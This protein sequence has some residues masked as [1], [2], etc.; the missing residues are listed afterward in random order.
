M[1]LLAIKLIVTPLVVLAATLAA[2]RWG[3]AVGGWLVGLPLTSGPVS[4]FLALEQG[5]AFAAHAAD[6]SLAGVIA[7]AAF[8]FGYA[9]LARRGAAAALVSGTLAYGAFAA[10]LLD[11]G[12]STFALFL[13]TVVALT[14]LLWLM[15][16]HPAQP[17]NAVGWGEALLRMA[18]TT[19][20]VVGLTSAATALGPGVAG[21]AA[22]FPLIGASIAVFAQLG[23]G[24]AAGVAVMRGMASALYAFAVFFLIVSLA[25]TRMPLAAAFG[26]ATMGALVAQA[27]T[28]RL[29]RPAQKERR[30]RWGAAAS[31]PNRG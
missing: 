5:P 4:V 10:V 12:L 20:L 15:P 13:A 29:L 1:S 27:A 21:S 3:D 18:A 25:M 24:Q 19:A 30:G 17:G 28:L 16:R 11:A 31:S 26:L 6:G 7:Q 14:I 22:S 8:C 9:A 2:R 23:P